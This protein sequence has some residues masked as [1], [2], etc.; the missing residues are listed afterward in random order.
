MKKYLILSFLILSISCT[1]LTKSEKEDLRELKSYGIRE[2]D[3]EAVA[4]PGLAGALNLLPGIG[5]FYLASGNGGDSTHYLYG[6]LNLLT[7]PL[8]ILWGIPE[9]SLPLL[10]DGGDTSSAVTATFLSSS[11]TGASSS[12]RVEALQARLDQLDQ[13]LREASADKLSQQAAGSVE[14]RRDDAALPQQPSQALFSSLQSQRASD[15]RAHHA[16]ASDVHSHLLEFIGSLNAAGRNLRSDC[17]DPDF[18][19]A[20]LVNSFH[21]KKVDICT[22]TSKLDETSPAKISS[23]HVVCYQ[24]QQARHTATDSIC[25]GRNVALHLPSFVG[26]AMTGFVEATWM[27]M[28]QGALAA[29]CNPTGP[30]TKDKFPLCLGDWFVS[31]FRQVTLRRV[32][33][34]TRLMRY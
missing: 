15:S 26:S 4:K 14:Q 21:G 13:Q 30:F 33:G 9:E 24:H 11:V 34:R 1:H 8:S 31:G 6:T 5:N 23:S 18:K 16:T 17:D 12:G 25:E 29:A 2:S 10:G 7:W 3:E 19:D 20:D 27:S 32:R 28:H 22:P